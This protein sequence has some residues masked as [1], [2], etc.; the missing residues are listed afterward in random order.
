MQLPSPGGGIM[1]DPMNFSSQ[2]NN[3]KRQVRLC[4]NLKP[5]NDKRQVR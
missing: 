2:P 1:P 3:N 5:N 4:K